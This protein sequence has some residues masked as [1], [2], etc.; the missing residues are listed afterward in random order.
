MKEDVYVGGR[1]RLL[2]PE[3]VFKNNM[4]CSRLYL[5][6]WLDI[7]SRLNEMLILSCRF[8]QEFLDRFCVT[9]INGSIKTRRSNCLNVSVSHNKHF[10]IYVKK[11]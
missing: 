4:S 1:N 6:L 5:D 8:P 9:G 10:V 7:D 11:L 3:I 2:L